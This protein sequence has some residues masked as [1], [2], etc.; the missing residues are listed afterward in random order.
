M[1]LASPLDALSQSESFGTTKVGEGHDELASFHDASKRLTPNRGM[2][3]GEGGVGRFFRI[4]AQG[5]ENRRR[6][7]NELERREDGMRCFKAR[8][9]VP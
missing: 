6:S 8:R 9:V 2:R 1:P 5:F 4:S 3:E 7:S